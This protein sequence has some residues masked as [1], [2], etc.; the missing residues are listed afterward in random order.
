MNMTLGALDPPAGL[1]SVDLAT[2]L[3][4]GGTNFRFHGLA[5]DN[6]YL[7]HP[8]CLYPIDC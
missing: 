3:S 6:D 7:H 5:V 8:I 2:C 1:E 4:Q